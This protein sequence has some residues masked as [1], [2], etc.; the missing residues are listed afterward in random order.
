MKF[1]YDIKNNFYKMYGEA[2]YLVTYKKKY[3]NG[4]NKPIK[5]YINNDIYLTVSSVILFI[6]TKLVRDLNFLVIPLFMAFIVSVLLLLLSLS[7]YYKYKKDNHKGEIII[8]ENG[9][10]DNSDINITFPWEKVE[11]IGVTKNMMAIVLDS[12]FVIILEPNNKIIKEIHKY[13]DV[14]VIENK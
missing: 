5:N 11:L 6:I 14:K 9:I 8:D 3:M 10:T 4:F 2:N 7:A 12:P 1:K 13:K